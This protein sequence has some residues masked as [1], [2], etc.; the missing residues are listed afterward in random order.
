QEAVEKQGA[1]AAAVT[2]ARAHGAQKALEKQGAKAAKVAR[3]QAGS[4][5]KKAAEQSRRAAKEA[6]ERSKPLVVPVVERAKPMVER[7]KPTVAKGAERVLEAA[8]SSSNGKT[9]KANEPSNVK[10]L[11][12]LLDEAVASGKKIPY[13]KPLVTRLI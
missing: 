5:G 12:R 11:R 13:D 1:K 3:A 9:K 10:E 6:V 7:A 8:Q 4:A 2:A